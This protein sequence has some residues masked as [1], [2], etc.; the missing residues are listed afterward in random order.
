MPSKAAMELAKDIQDYLGMQNCTKPI[1]QMIAK[2][3][4]IGVADLL[5]KSDKV[6]FLAHEHVSPLLAKDLRLQIE[7]WKSEKKTDT[8]PKTS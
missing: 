4:D 2:R 7:E 6:L 5:Q 1:Q 8:P 3:I